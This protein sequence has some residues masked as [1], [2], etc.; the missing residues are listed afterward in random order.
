VEGNP[1]SLIDLFPGYSYNLRASVL[2][3]DSQIPLGPN[4]TAIEY[5][6]L[7]LKS[8]TEAQRRQRVLD[9]QTI[10]GPFGRNLHE[11]LLAVDGQGR[12]INNGSR[13]VL[14]GREEERT[15]HDEVGMRHFYEEWSR[16]MGRP[17]SDPT[18]RAALE[19]PVRA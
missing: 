18:K 16:R 5:R 15:I 11:D 7:G 17:A 19:K 3:V 4:R 14:H 2:R 13:Y 9:N 1:W 8:D 10:W 6:S 12:A